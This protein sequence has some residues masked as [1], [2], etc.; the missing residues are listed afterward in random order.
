M[1]RYYAG[2]RAYRKAGPPP[3]AFRVLGPLVVVTTLALLGSGVSLILI[4]PASARSAFLSLGPLQISALMMHKGVFVIW[5]AVTGLHT[6]AR[7]VPAF[8][9]TV[10]RPSAPLASGSRARAA[11]LAVTTVVAIAAAV[12]AIPLAKPW[13]HDRPHHFHRTAQGPSR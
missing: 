10:M 5:A 2:N 4:T 9:L 13:Q 7:I 11:A 3:M 1:A 6:L 8:S 12:V